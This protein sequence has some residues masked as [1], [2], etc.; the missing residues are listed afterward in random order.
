MLSLATAMLAVLGSC[1]GGAAAQDSVVG[2]AQPGTMADTFTLPY[3]EFDST[4]ASGCGN[5]FAGCS[6]EFITISHDVAGTV[7]VIDDCTFRVQ[8]W[9]FDGLGPAVEWYAP[10][11]SPLD[12]LWL[13]S[14]RSTPPWPCRSPEAVGSPHC[15]SHLVP[16]WCAVYQQC[17]TF[18]L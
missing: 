8:G 10:V 13:L 12:H 17:C 5:S 6:G 3:S 2:E 7:E 9:Q 14:N 18:V 15:V 4:A 1:L 16:R 11:H